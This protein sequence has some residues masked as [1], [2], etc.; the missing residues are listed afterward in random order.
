MPHSLKKIICDLHCFLNKNPF[1]EFVI[2]G[3]RSFQTLAALPTSKGGP[4]TN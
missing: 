1:Q 4:V 2:L 3:T